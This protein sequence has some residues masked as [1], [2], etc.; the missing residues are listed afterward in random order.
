MLE[1]T[2]FWQGLAL[3]IPILSILSFPLEMLYSLV[4]VKSF[5]I[6]LL[7]FWA[8]GSRK[9]GCLQCLQMA[10]CRDGLFIVSCPDTTGSSWIPISVFSILVIL[11]IFQNSL[12]FFSIVLGIVSIRFCFLKNLQWLY[13]NFLQSLSIVIFL[14]T[15]VLLFYILFSYI[16]GFCHVGGCT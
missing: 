16:E 7:Y 14:E 3:W 1:I 5:L 2:T 11:L 12:L 9:E 13:I 8:F 15:L 6:K 4:V 10:I